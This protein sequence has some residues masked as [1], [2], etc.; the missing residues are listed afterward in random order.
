M[1]QILQQTAAHAAD[2]LPV[3]GYWAE[4]DTL[5]PTAAARHFWDAP[6]CTVLRESG[7]LKGEKGSLQYLPPTDTLP[8]GFVLLNLGSEKQR[9]PDGIGAVIRS[10]V[11]KLRW[12]SNLAFAAS[13]WFAGTAEDNARLFALFAT[14]A[15]A[16]KTGWKKDAKEKPSV[17][18]RWI[19]EGNQSSALSEGSIIGAAVVEACRLADTP[20]NLC[21]PSFLAAWAE[22][23]AAA[24]ESVFCNVLRRAELEAAGFGGLLSVA[25]GSA[26]EPALIE[27]AYNGGSPDEAPIV[28]VGKGITFDAGGISLKPAQKMGDMIYDMT[29]AATVLATLRAAADLRMPINLV[30]IAPACENL[31]SGTALKPGDVITTYSGRTVE[32]QNTDA[33]GRL[34]LADALTKALEKKPALI[35]DV[36]TLTGACVVALGSTYT[37]L[38]ANCDDLADKLLDAGRR[39]GDIAWRMPLH[40]DYTELMQSTYADLVNVSPERGAGASTAA[41]FLETFVEETPWAHLDIAGTSNTNGK[42]HAATGRPVPLLVEFL[43]RRAEQKTA[44]CEGKQEASV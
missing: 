7:V 43:R 3:V 33:E 17:T 36:A 35:V 8:K 22:E 32:V 2:S 21:T 14:R 6:F 18:V 30:A 37:G 38:F 9:T 26:E 40:A 13:D 34:I 5:T 20:S 42:N 39:A 11:Q 27:L 41:A 1:T 44:P 19:G 12:A 10:T 31:P 25:K 16:P 28:L 4:G 24:H 15:L 23:T 29:G